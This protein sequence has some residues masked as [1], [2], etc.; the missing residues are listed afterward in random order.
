MTSQNIKND[1]EIKMADTIAKY[2]E[3]NLILIHVSTPIGVQEK[4]IYHECEVLI[5]QELSHDSIAHL[6]CALPI[7][8]IRAVA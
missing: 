3:A 1:V 5:I 6:N 8:K 4:R 2:F 7:T